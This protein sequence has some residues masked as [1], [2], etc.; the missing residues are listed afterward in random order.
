MSCCFENNQHCCALTCRADVCCLCFTVTLV[1]RY[2]KVATVTVD[3]IQLRQGIR[4]FAQGKRADDSAPYIA[5]NMN[6]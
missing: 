3:C 4:E 1:Y 5:G 2:I 6:K